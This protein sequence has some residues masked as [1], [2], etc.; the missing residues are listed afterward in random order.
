MRVDKQPAVL[1]HARRYRETSLLLDWFTR[2]FGRVAVVAR[3]SNRK[4]AGAP[5]P[6]SGYQIGWAGRSS[7]ATMSQCDLIEHRWLS[8]DAATVGLYVNELLMRLLPERDAHPSVF[9]LYWQIVSLLTQTARGAELER[10]L[11]GFE[12]H[13]LEVLGYALE[14]SRDADTGEPVVPDRH[15]V[16][17]V[18]H[19]LRR[20]VGEPTEDSYRGSMLLALGAGEAPDIES[21][22]AAKRLLRQALAPLLAGKPLNTPTFLG[23]R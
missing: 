3:N 18:D 12:L 22:R 23:P 15:Y 5:S 17:D 16:F 4:G 21:R 14:L 6:F 11:R 7:L 9:A 2:D 1:L 10:L 19:G 8:G 13:L 20:Q